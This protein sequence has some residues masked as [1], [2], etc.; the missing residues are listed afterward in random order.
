[1]EDYMGK[2]WTDEETIPFQT[3]WREAEILP[4]DGSKKG[5]IDADS[6]RFRIDVGFEIDVRAYCRL[7]AE[8]TITTPDDRTDDGVDAWEIHGQ[9]RPLGLL[10]KERAE[11]LLRS[12]ESLRVWSFDS[13]E[14]GKYGRWLVIV[15]V[16]VEGGWK[17]L[18][19]I[20]VEEG[21]AKFE[22]Y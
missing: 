16:P 21:H 1:V 8:G 18:G 4:D 13:G 19:D 15:L 12:A 6:F 3:P 22:S 17:S 14:K 10:A 9:E 2:I 5:I 11:E 20:L 7:L